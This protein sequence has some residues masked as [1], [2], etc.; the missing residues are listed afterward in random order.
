M[1]KGLAGVLASLCFTA[2]ATA[3]VLDDDRADILYHRYDGGG[4]TIDGPSLLVR[5]KFAEQYAATASYYIDMVSSASID[6]IT[7]ASPY[8]EERKEYG[9]GFEYLRDKVTYRLGYSNS[10]ENDYD[11]D[12]AYASISQDMFGDLT[13]LTLSF[14]RG[15][16]QVFR[17]GD[18]TFSDQVDRRV[19]GVDLSQILTRRLIAGLSFETVT[20]E[21][22]LNN[23][24]RSVRYLDPE[25][26]VGYSYQAEIYPGTRT[27]SALALRGRYNLAERMAVHGEYRYYTDD[28]DIRAHT[29]EVGYTYGL[30]DNW[31]LDVHYRY[32]TQDGADFYSDLFPRRDFQ[33]FLARDK[34]LATMTSQT[35]GFGVSY[36]FTAPWLSFLQKS[37]VNLRYDLILFD[38]DDFRDVRSGGY[39]PGTEPLYQFDANVLQLFVSG[40][41]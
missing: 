31:I 21:G 26:A 18:D 12:T 2:A 20:E 19:Y 5:K 1:R 4:V 22:F 3:G 25:S 35:F 34:E 10:R 14:A 11:A 29:A 39:E 30:G 37:S 13:T 23:P 17:R 41:F 6:V 7:T 33:N 40:W 16:D 38:Y 36:G 32:H 24:Y 28:W 8:A 27:G 9:L 15:W